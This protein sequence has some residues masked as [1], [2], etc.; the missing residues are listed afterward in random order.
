M[1]QFIHVSPR[2]L[3]GVISKLGPLGE[4]PGLLKF[5]RNVDNAKI[6]SGFV[7]ELADA[8]E[9]YQVR[10]PHHG[11]M[12]NKHPARFH[13]NKEC[14]KGQGISTA[15]PR[16]SMMKPRTS[17]IEPRTSMMTPRTSWLGSPLL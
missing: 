7:Q 6:L 9:Y 2:R 11:V 3:D 17:M 15:I 16:I 13:Y 4:E 10:A 8:V 1:W 12:F 5:L 14:M